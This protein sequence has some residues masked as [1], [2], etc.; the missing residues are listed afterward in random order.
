MKK[1]EL[2]AI[3]AQQTAAVIA[4]AGHG[5]TEM[6]VDMVEYAGGRQLLLT[7]THAGVDALQ[8]RLNH[9]CISKTK[10]AISTIAA[11]CTKWG[12]A[13]CHTSAVDTALSPYRTKD[14]AR[15]YYS[16]FYDG[17]KQL[18]QHEWAG[19]VLQE[20]YS[21]VI[22]D[23]YQ[24]CIQTNHEMFLILSRYLPVRVLGDPLQ[25]I[26]SFS[27]QQLVDWNCLGYPVV[28]V[29]TSPWR[30]SKTNPS[31]GQYLNDIRDSLWPTLAGHQCTLDIDSCY[32]SICVID[33]QHFDVYS[34]LSEFRQYKTVLYLTKWEAQQTNFCLRHPNI[35]Q[36][37]EKQECEDLFRFADSFSNKSGIDLM[38]E[39]IEFESKCSIKVK[40]ELTSFINSLGR[41]SFDF[42]RIKKNI[43]FGQLLSEVQAVDKHETILRILNWFEKN[44]TFKCY[45][46]E[47]HSEMIRSVR[48]SRD[49]GISIYEAA[50][51]IRKD[52]AL[53]KRYQG[54]KCL[55][56]RTLLSKGLEFDCVIID[57][58]T[59]L[60][61]K[62]FYVAMTRAMK[63]IYILSPTNRLTLNP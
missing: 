30:W 63:K 56:S 19:R 1:Q 8:K 44:P 13:Y 48:Y 14:E 46:K 6:I 2:E 57:M 36:L 54:F 16:Q 59:P 26:F 12:M 21:G 42:G 37:D 43:E 45:R 62:E 60:S 10:Y 41:G 49:H 29:D 17:A 28:D 27:G 9:R 25:G 55:S 23:E 24:D 31:L 5:K 35:F 47:L 61:A 11:F 4:P 22:V 20:S 51:H 15:R 52:P 7:H 50:G 34:M 53:Q 32:G 33:P 38:L 18:F 3:F 58:S 39:I 40:S